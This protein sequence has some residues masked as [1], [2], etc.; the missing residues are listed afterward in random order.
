MAMT[1]KKSMAAV[2]SAAMAVNMAAA[3]AMVNADTTKYEFEDGTLSGCT[4]QESGT[5]RYQ[6]GASGDKFVFLENGGEI[7]SVTV[8]VPETGMYE[9][10]L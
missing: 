6:E 7:A 2:I 9:V 1:I 5:E 4:V 8:N 10:E 3:S